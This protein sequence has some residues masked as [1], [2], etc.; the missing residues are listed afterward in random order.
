MARAKYAAEHGYRRRIDERITMK[1][2]IF[3]KFKD[4]NKELEKILEKKD[5]SKDTKNLLLSM[6]YKLEISYND[7]FIV[8]RKCKSKQEYLENILNN[9]K[10]C[11]HIE[12]IKPSHQEFETFK[13]EN[14]LYQVDLKLKSIRAIANELA[15][16]SAILELNNFQIYLNENYNLI[17]NSM[18]YLLNMAYDMENVEVLRDFNAWSWNTLVSEIKDIHINLVYQNLKI[19]LNFNLFDRVDENIEIDIV[20]VMEQDLLKQYDEKTVK[21]FLNLIF[22][23]S[24]LIYIRIS[25]NEKKRL[26]EEKETLQLDLQEIKDKKTYVE[27]ITKEK[28]KLA[29]ELKQLD[30]VMNNRELLIEEYERRNRSLSQYNKI[31][32]I[33]H[34]MEKMQKERKKI[35]EK[36]N[37]CNEKIEPKNY[38]E[39][40]NKLQQDEALLKGIQFDQNNQVEPSLYQL[41][42]LFI[43]NILS[44]KIAKLETKN[45][46]IDCLYELRYYGLLPYRG[47]LLIQDIEE[48]ENELKQVEKILIQ[49]LYAAKLINTISTNEQNDIEMI[50]NIF[51]LRMINLQD[52]YLVVNKKEK[53]YTIQIYDEKEALEKEFEIELEFHKKDKVK[54]NRKIKLFI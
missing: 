27:K 33:S 16:L 15:L 29:E 6:F 44:Q 39:N 36:M 32:S 4:Y 9:I 42:K 8:K 35:L 10:Q 22:K 46:L 18:P 50:Q 37:A 40:K 17:R 5:F 12:L 20:Q 48:L 13:Q 52:I 25:E 19:A 1:E 41:Q 21:K 53:K 23:I 3:S 49:K 26:L 31:F 2:E 47:N 30:L 11:N 38:L 34:L 28:K 51:Q 54:L 14:G 45:E 43:R 7:Y 24:I